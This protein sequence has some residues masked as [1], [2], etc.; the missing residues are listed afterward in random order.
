MASA[1]GGGSRSGRQVVAMVC[2]DCLAAPECLT[3]AG[4]GATC[5]LDAFRRV[6]VRLLVSCV[7]DICCPKSRGT[8]QFGRGPRHVHDKPIEVLVR[9][10]DIR[11][12]LCDMEVDGDEVV[13][14]STHSAKEFMKKSPVI[15]FGPARQGKTTMVNDILEELGDFSRPGKES[16]LLPCTRGV[17]VFKT[18]C[19]SWTTPGV[20]EE[21]LL[22]DSE[23]WEFG[24]TPKNLFKECMKLAEKEQIQLKLL[25]HRLVLVS[26]LSAE[27]RSWV[28]D[29]KFLDLLDGVC[30]QAAKE[31]GGGKPVLVPVVSKED[32][33]NDGLERDIVLR[34]YTKSLEKRVG[35]TV[36]VHPALGVTHKAD[37]DGRRPS[38]KQLREK[39]A[40]ICT[41]QLMSEHILLAVKDIIAGDLQRYL[42]E[43]DEEGID[44]SHAL[45]RRFLWI[46][47]RH[48]GLRIKDL[49]KIEPT[50]DWKQV[51]GVCRDLKGWRAPKAGAEATDG[52]HWDPRREKGPRP[53]GFS[54]SPSGSSTVKS[55]GSDHV[56]IR[57]TSTSTTRTASGEF[58]LSP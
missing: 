37:A 13:E 43:W 28:E 45:V 40:A 53:K 44:A 22:L 4:A 20:E 2:L 27:N 34:A 31:A 19:S 52:W 24:R 57:G 11:L 5:L 16:F 17:Q 35:S 47:A 15:L 39:L 9:A 58:S 48:H 12:E 54:R 56:S 6:A 29:P 21:V 25:Q 42:M 30:R 50:M 23:G 26:V 46:V 18:Q 51:E 3:A 38:I 36:E 32:L 33:L 8:P 49:Y 10:D 14:R 1:I 7:I 55:S 41:K